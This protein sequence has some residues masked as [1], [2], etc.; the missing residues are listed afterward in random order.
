[1]S[2]T[3]L[4]VETTDDGEV[5]H[6]VSPSLEELQKRVNDYM[7]KAVIEAETSEDE[8]ESI[9]EQIK[10]MLHLDVHPGNLTK[11]VMNDVIGE[12]RTAA[13]F[14]TICTRMARV[15]YSRG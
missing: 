10:R 2:D 8:V 14:E 4:A 13:I 5:L 12:R 9:S 6:G 7:I 1:M 11:L 15:V 3:W